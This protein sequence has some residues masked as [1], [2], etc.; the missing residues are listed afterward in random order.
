M[1]INLTD[2]QQA[3]LREAWAEHD[4]AES[5]VR[6]AKVQIYRL[7]VAIGGSEA[8]ATRDRQGNPV[9]HLISVSGNDD[10]E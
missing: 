8:S 1:D 3:I 2:E 5:M 9:I 6:A 4:A 10:T 7:A